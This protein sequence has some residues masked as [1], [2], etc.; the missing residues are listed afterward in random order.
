MDADNIVK[1]YTNGEITVVW[2]PALCI[3]SRKCWTGLPAVF[4]PRVKP[5]VKMEGAA[6][7]A[8]IAQVDI[9]PSGALSYY[10]NT[11]QND[12]GAEQPA[13]GTAVKVEVSKNGPYLVHGEITL[14][15]KHGVETTRTKVTALCRCGRSANKP[16]CDGTH[17]TCGFK[18]E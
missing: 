8:I 6:T 9:C 7:D 12:T 1:K 13:A 14:K 17:R 5:W 16:F 4:D 3:H 15:D 11:G 2:K 18:D 10:R